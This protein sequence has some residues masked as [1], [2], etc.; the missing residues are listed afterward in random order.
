MNGPLTYIAGPYSAPTVEGIAANVAAAL[1]VLHHLLDAG[2]PAICPHLSHYA[3]QQRARDYEDWMALD[4]EL[5]RRC[6]V[7]LR[8]HGES[9]GADREVGV[10]RWH[11][12]PVVCLPERIRWAD[13]GG[14]VRRTVAESFPDP[15][16]L[17]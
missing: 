10:A 7:V 8:L 1:D 6:D 14:I 5:V 11:N 13:L 4:F 12:I 15:R 16:G 9:P 3:E 2:I 17:V